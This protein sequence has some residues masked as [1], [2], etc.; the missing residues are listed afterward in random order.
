MDHQNNVLG[1]IEA[2]CSYSTFVATDIVDV[3]IPLNIGDTSRD[4]YVLS[5]IEEERRG[6]QDEEG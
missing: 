2:G 5:I 6:K 1:K 3:L 4:M